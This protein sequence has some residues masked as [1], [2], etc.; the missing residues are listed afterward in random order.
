MK[1]FLQTNYTVCYYI[2]KTYLLFLGYCIS[3]LSDSKR[4]SSHIPYRDSKLTKLLA[5]SLAGNGAT[6]MV[7]LFIFCNYL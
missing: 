2:N 1:G 4:K 6:L 5:D 3:S 7:F